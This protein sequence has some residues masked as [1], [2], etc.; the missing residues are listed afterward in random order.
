MIESRRSRNRQ[1]VAGSAAHE[2]PF[3]TRPC[4][5]RCRLKCRA[6]RQFAQALTP[7]LGL[8]ENF[9]QCVCAIFRQSVGW[10][11]CL[12]GRSY[13]TVTFTPASFS[14]RKSDFGIRR[15]V[16]TSCTDVTGMMLHKLRRPNLLESHTA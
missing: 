8:G 15:S 16:T 12:S 1:I 4:H 2:N 10:V 9:A 6:G 5:L 13:T 7:A 14:A 11:H 3:R